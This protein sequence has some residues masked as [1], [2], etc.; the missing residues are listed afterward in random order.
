MRGA[1][2]DSLWG[3]IPG[4]DVGMVAFDACLAG[5]VRVAADFALSTWVASLVFSDLSLALEDVVDV[6]ARRCRGG[7]LHGRLM[8][9]NGRATLQ[10]QGCPF[11]LQPY[12][13]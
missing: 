13:S 1:G 2:I 4:A 10:P 11:T 8:A 9:L 3:R 12:Q 5:D 6:A 7:W